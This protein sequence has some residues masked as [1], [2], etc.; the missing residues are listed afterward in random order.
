MKYYK[1][2]NKENSVVSVWAKNGKLERA[3]WYDKIIFGLDTSAKDFRDWIDPETV[4]YRPL[5][6]TDFG[7]SLLSEITE[8][9]ALEIIV[10]NG[11]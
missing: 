5:N 2:I 4:G 9:E 3:L 10:L 6:Q 11:I 1:V 8:Q 7:M